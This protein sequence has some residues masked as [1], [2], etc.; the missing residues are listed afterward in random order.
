[1]GRALYDNGNFIGKDVRYGTD[2]GVWDAQAHYAT[3]PP[4][5][6]LYINRSASYGDATYSSFPS[7]VTLSGSGTATSSLWTYTNGVCD[8]L[9]IQ[10]TG[11]GTYRITS[12]SRF[13]YYG[14]AGGQ[15]I[16]YVGVFD[17]SSLGSTSLGITAVV[18]N[19]VENNTNRYPEEYALSTPIT[20]NKGSWYAVALG[21]VS[22][23]SV[24]VNNT[25]PA[26][27]YIPNGYARTSVTTDYGTVNFGSL[28]SY[29]FNHP[30]ITAFQ[31]SRGTNSSQ[32]QLP[33]IGL[34]F[35]GAYA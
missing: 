13:S 23:Y 16:T 17:G 24:S 22:G 34:E 28:E 35:D 21:Y 29:W 15:Q 19:P 31:N 11:T 4:P 12:L 2:H 10:V 5:V 14:T 1:M 7:N 6:P 27:A 30:S 32:G 25:N 26:S 3:K 20:L 9:R 18:R 33:V 8:A